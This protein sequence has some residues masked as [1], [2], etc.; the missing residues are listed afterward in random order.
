MTPNKGT[1]ASLLKEF[2]TLHNI[3]YLVVSFNIQKKYPHKMNGNCSIYD[4][5]IR[6]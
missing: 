1:T 6:V 4:Y 2:L 5:L 3:T